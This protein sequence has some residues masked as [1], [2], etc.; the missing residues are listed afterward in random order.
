VEFSRRCEDS[1]PPQKNFA[2]T[3]PPQKQKQKRKQ[4][5]K[6]KQKQ[7][8]SLPQLGALEKQQLPQ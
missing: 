5:Q 2:K 7:T 4:K 8:Q 6:Q 1:I 3:F